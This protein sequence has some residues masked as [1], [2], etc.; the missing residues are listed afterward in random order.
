MFAYTISSVMLANFFGVPVTPHN[1]S[2]SDNVQV[3]SQLA[4]ELLGDDAQRSLE[5][6]IRLGRLG[7]V[8]LPVLSAAARDYREEIRANAAA[9]IRELAATVPEAVDVLLP[10]LTDKSERVVREACG[11][12]AAFGRG[13]QPAVKCL[14]KLLQTGNSSL[15]EAAAFALRGIGPAARDAEAALAGAATRFANDRSLACYEVVRALE[16]VGIRDAKTVRALVPL[17]QTGD[18]LLTVAAADAIGRAGELGALAAPA[19]RPL[20]QSRD[21]EVRLAAA[22]ALG[23]V[24]GGDEPVHVLLELIADTDGEVRL[25]AV[26]GLEELGSRANKAIPSLRAVAER[27]RDEA[28]RSAAAAAIQTIQSAVR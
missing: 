3:V 2:S 5:A 27:D 1:D 25:G 10:L 4:T 28:V 15:A 13:G 24:V 21:S 9:G 17:L 8:G 22:V 19:L 12:L 18:A 20:L 16:S 11:A 26:L 7:G 14:V 23:R 6:V